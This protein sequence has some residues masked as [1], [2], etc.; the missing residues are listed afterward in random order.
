M[1]S[2]RPEKLVRSSAVQAEKV[3]A[4]WGRGERD[5]PGGELY[6]GSYQWFS[7]VKK[8]IGDCNMKC[9]SRTHDVRRVPKDAPIKEIVR[10]R[11]HGEHHYMAMKGVTQFG[12]GQLGRG[13]KRDFL[14][15]S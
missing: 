6:M 9:G 14:M 8:L 12:E 5:N 3:S 4:A 10:M 1:R 11:G 13:R 15:R 2:W 7:K